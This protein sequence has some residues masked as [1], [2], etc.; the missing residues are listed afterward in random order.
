VLKRPWI[1]ALDNRGR[2]GPESWPISSES[3]FV[4]LR[5]PLALRMRRDEPAIV[6][7]ERPAHAL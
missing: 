3:Q 2:M 4:K 1:L 6:F 7:S 5:A